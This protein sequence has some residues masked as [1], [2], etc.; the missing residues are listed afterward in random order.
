MPLIITR[1]PAASA[2]SRSHVNAASDVRQAARLCAV[3]SRTSRIWLGDVVDGIVR[4]SPPRRTAAAARLRGADCPG[5]T[6]GDARRRRSHR[7]GPRTPPAP[8][9]T[10]RS[11]IVR[12]SGIGTVSTG[13]S[14]RKRNPTGVWVLRANSSSCFSVGAVSPPATPRSAGTGW[15]QI[16][17]ID[18]GPGASPLEHARSHLDSDTHDCSPPRRTSDRRH[19][20]TVPGGCDGPSCRLPRP[21]L[22]DFGCRR[23][24]GPNPLQQ[25]RRR[26][27]GRVLRDRAALRTLPSAPTGA[28]PPTRRGPTSTARSHASTNDI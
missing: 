12:K 8:A 4:A 19:R 5:T 2:C 20:S 22:V 17:V 28:A 7:A 23:P 16:L 3:Q 14:S 18:A 27:I 21:S 24:L 11:P 15:S 10:G 9:P 25:H 6:P 13:G 1:T 26:L